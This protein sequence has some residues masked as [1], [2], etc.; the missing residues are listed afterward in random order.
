MIAHRARE[1]ASEIAE[2]ID[3]LAFI[4][5]LKAAPPVADSAA[6]EEWC[7]T[8]DDFQNGLRAVLAGEVV[9]SLRVNRD[10]LG[11]I[12][13]VYAH[14]SVISAGAPLPATLFNVVDVAWT[15]IE[16]TMGPIQA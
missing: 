15:E 10:L 1:I 8:L 12:E 7:T 4:R 11:S 14:L 13:D 9:T 16:R 5:S 6:L 3:C 2:G